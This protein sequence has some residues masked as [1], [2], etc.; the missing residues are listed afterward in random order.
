M[1]LDLRCPENI[2]RMIKAATEKLGSID[3]F[4]ADAGFGYYGKTKADWPHMEDIFKLNVFS[5]IYALT[6]MC[7]VFPDRPFH[8]VIIDSGAGRMPL[9][10]YSLY[11]ST[12]IRPGRI[13]TF[14][15]V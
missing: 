3:I 11:C 5:P 15:P 4:V 2:D 12:K 6:K 7:E 13:F 14:F 1:A 9:P 8:F 10:G